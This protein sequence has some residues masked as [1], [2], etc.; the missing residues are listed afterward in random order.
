MPPTVRPRRDLSFVLKIAAA[1]VLATAADV[2]FWRPG[3]SATGGFAL[4]L[5]ATVALLVPR[6]ARD[7]KAICALAAALVLALVL[8]EAP[9]PLAWILFWSALTLA[10]LLPRA[11]RFDDAWRWSQRLAAQA[12]VGAFGPL[13]DAWAL[14]RLGKGARRWSWGSLVAVLALPL[15]GGALFLTL[16]AA[17]NPVI[18]QVLSNLHLPRI[19]EEA[20]LRAVLWLIAL[21]GVWGV[22]RPRRRRALPAI[23]RRRSPAGPPVPAASVTLSLL[24][25]NL[26]FLMQNGLDAAILWGGAGLPEGV[27]LAQYAHRGAYPLIA[28]ALLAG[29]FVLLFLDP[30]SPLAR[31]RLVRWLVVAWVAQNLFLVASSILR[32]VDYVE[33]YSLTRLRIAALAWMVLVGLGLVLVCWRMLR[34]RSGA[35]LINANALAAVVVLTL[36]CTIDLGSVAAAWNVRH[37]QE[38]DGQGA[39]L[40][41][42]YLRALDD[43]ALVS[44]AELER[45]A[46]PELADRATYVRELGEARLRERQSDWRTWTWRG[47]R[48]LA[49]LDAF[50]SQQPVRPS[51]AGERTY[52]GTILQPQPPAKPPVAE[53][54]VAGPP[55]AEVAADVAAPQLTP[56]AEH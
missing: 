18:A 38:I 30:R 19:S 40:D 29:L 1:L 12:V 42:G 3:G 48:R 7:P 28:T 36:G 45:R 35:W 56:G 52:G 14:S 6:A 37:A 33:T 31:D 50:R 32:T 10:V 21:T 55:V 4:A 5:T 17:A 20:I 53:P 24:V 47:A 46:V 41:L 51:L 13:L 44:L 49:R 25:F 8:V 11:A 2:V 27:T 23:A 15:A 26:L 9:G 34:G 22:L 43:S 54:P 16:F 39:A